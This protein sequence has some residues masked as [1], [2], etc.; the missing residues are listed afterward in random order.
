MYL[1]KCTFIAIYFIVLSIP[2]PM[3]PISDPMLIYVTFYIAMNDR[4]AHFKK[5]VCKMRIFE[6]QYLYC[7][8]HSSE[9]KKYETSQGDCEKKIQPYC[10]QRCVAVWLC[11]CVAVELIFRCF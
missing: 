4:Q 5:S 7:R 2:F 9:G 10:A 1:H 11:G 3:K 8:A 6:S